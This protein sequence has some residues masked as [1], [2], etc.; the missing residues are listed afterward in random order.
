MPLEIKNVPLGISK[1]PFSYFQRPALFL[2]LGETLAF[3][4]DFEFLY[5]A[6]SKAVPRGGGS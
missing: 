3:I 2:A 5:L 6:E 1:V 4:I